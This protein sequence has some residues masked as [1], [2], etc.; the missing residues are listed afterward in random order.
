M[1]TTQNLTMLD[2][3]RGL[4]ALYVILNHLFGTNFV[5]S[6]RD[7][8][9]L[10]RFGQEAVIIFFLISGFVIQYSYNRA[11][12]KSF[13]V[14]FIKRFKRI[15]IPLSIVFASNYFVFLLQKTPVHIT[16][17]AFLGNIFM[18]QDLPYPARLNILCEPL[19]NNIPLWS[20]SYEWWFYMLF[21][22]ILMTIERKSSGTI[23]LLCLIATLSYIIYPFF[24]NRLIM[25]LTI[26]WIGVDLAK[27]YDL[28]KLSL[29][30][31]KKQFFTLIICIIL[32]FINF[33]I[34]GNGLASLR[35]GGVGFSPFLELRNFIFTLL[36]LLIALI[37]RNRQWIGFD[38][39]I[40]AFL[41]LAPISF[42]LYISHWFL[43]VRAHYF[44]NIIE[45]KLVRYASYF[46]VCFAFSY[47]VERIIYTYLDK[48]ISFFS[49]AKQ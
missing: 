33:I 46:F 9:Y 39:T 43:I 28:K 6:N 23:Y 24:I 42:C 4:A 27:L 16:Y 11:K 17:Q 31:L 20:L 41:P 13:K 26:W 36:A 29:S 49:K 21:F 10:F 2:S 30:S 34:H 14:F 38:K 45:N 37:W 5:I 1:K 47:I 8:S 22:P 40:G 48:K 19:F 32:L 25:Y 15:Y 12:N 35:N 44:D 18:L 3:L 7:Y